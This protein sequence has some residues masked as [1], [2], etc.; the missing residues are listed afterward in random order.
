M[1]LHHVHVLL[2]LALLADET[3]FHA[4]LLLQ[5]VNVLCVASEKFSFLRQH[6]DE[7]M[8]WRWFC[9]QCLRVQLRNKRVKDGGRGAVAKQVGIEQILPLQNRFRVLLLDKV[10][11]AISRAKVL[12]P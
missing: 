9:L 8:G 11:Q 3:G 2:D 5:A 1:Q 10:V 7:V 4:Q 12:A 6:F